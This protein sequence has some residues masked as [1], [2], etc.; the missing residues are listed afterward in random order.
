[1][2]VGFALFVVAAS[3]AYPM[4]LE[5]ERGQVDIAPL[6]VVLTS[7]YAIEV[8]RRAHV[9][10]EGRGRKQRCTPLGRETAATM[11]A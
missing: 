3:A 2:P 10:C 6:F 11:D 5:L 7:L 4:R 8:S 9:R 1:V